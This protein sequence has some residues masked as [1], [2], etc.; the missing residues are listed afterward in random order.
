M[1]RSDS[2]FAWADA[3]RRDAS[4]A[5]TSSRSGNVEMPM[6]SQE[7]G[8]LI[9]DMLLELSWLV[10]SAFLSIFNIRALSERI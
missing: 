7:R 2:G 6:R 10:A 3:K 4:D 9:S 1:R 5:K 8:L